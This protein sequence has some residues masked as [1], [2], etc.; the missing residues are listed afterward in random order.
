MNL[1]IENPQEVSSYTTQEI[2]ESTGKTEKS[3]YIQGIFSTPGKKNKNGRVYSED[4]WKREVEKYQKEIHNKTVNS[5]GEWEH[6]A[7]SNVDPMNAVFR[8]V[9]LKMENGL[10]WGKAKILNNG[11]EKTNQL[12]ALI[13]E[14]LKIGV[15]S[16]GVGSVGNNGIV[17]EFRLITYDAVSNPS[18]YNANLSGINE[19]IVF[20]NGIV[21]N[22]EYALNESGEIYQK[23]FTS[24]DSFKVKDTILNII[25]D[26]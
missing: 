11:S 7:R 4:L 14:G 26:L 2:N 6:P 1:I 22:S 25:K 17:T 16:R 20:K 15:S 3:Y 9:E 5:L 24:A 18:D 21:V 19:N 13:D 12:K 8:I 10:V 23:A